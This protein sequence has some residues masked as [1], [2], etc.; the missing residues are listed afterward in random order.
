MYS[1]SIIDVDLQDILRRLLKVRKTKSLYVDLKHEEVCYIIKKSQDVFRSQPMLIEL[2]PP[3]HICGDIHGQF[4]DLLRILSQGKHPPTANYLFLGDYVD[5]GRN[6]I[7]VLCLLLIY[8]IKYPGN[9]FML[10][11]N[12]ECIRINSMYGFLTECRHR[13]NLE[14]YQKF[15]DLFAWLPLAALVADKIF[16]CHGGPSPDIKSFDC[17]RS[18]PRPMHDVPD[19]GI[20]SDLLWA[21]PFPGSGWVQSDRGVSY[22]FG[23][24]VLNKF[25]ARLGLDLVARAH[26]VLHSTQ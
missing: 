20:A 4:H 14:I 21:D 12:H 11:G 16:C 23:A 13:Y 19:S 18:L 25:L 2:N 3:L 24:D 15:N 17:V 1:D 6:S 9:V 22:L 7:E 10:R 26:Q 5:R 8:K